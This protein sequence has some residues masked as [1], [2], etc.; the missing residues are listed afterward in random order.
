MISFLVFLAF[1]FAPAQCLI[2]GFT[3]SFLNKLIDLNTSQI[4]S[5]LSL[6]VVVDLSL[7]SS[8]LR[9]FIAED[10]GVERCKQFGC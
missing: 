9:I 6:F 8:L 1:D 7:L 4:I 5:L 10:L 2:F 3:V